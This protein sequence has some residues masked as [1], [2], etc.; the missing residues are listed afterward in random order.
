MQPPHFPQTCTSSGRWL[1]VTILTW[2]FDFPNIFYMTHSTSFSGG[3]WNFPIAQAAIE[4]S[5][6]KQKRPWLNTCGCDIKKLQ[7]KNMSCGRIMESL[8]P[9]GLSRHLYPFRGWWWGQERELGISGQ[10]GQICRLNAAPKF[11]CCRAI[12]V[13]SRKVIQKN[14]FE[15]NRLR[16][17]WVSRKIVW[18]GKLVPH[19]CVCNSSQDKKVPKQRTE[20]NGWG[21][22]RSRGDV[23]W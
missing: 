15:G 7:S 18:L 1:Y 22:G 4:P 21:E 13:L 23:L 19:S 5:L 20:N 10:S 17:G 11:T 12:P 9:A 14:P 16:G 3:K 8:A 2:Y 6:L